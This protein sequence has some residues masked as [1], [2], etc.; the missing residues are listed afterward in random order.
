MKEKVK[1]YFKIIVLCALLLL[2]A[3]YSE[4]TNKTM[5]EDGSLPRNAFGE[6]SNEVDLVLNADGLEK[7]LPYEVTVEEKHITEKDA[8]QYF[9]QAESEI[10]STL[11]AEGDQATHVEHNLNVNTSYV[12]G[13]V[14][15]DWNFLDS[16]AINYEGEL[17]PEFMQASGEVVQVQVELTCYEYKETYAFSVQIYPAPL[18]KTEKLI[19]DIQAELEKESGK[20]DEDTFHLPQVVDGVKLRWSEPQE[21]L[22]LKIFLLEIIVCILLPFLEKEKQ[23][24]RLKARQERMRLDYSDIVSKMAILVGAGMSV[25][26]A[27]D[28]ISARYLVD[29]KKNMVI[30]KPAYEEM[31]T[32]SYELQDGAS[33]RD[34]FQNFSERVGVGEYHRLSRI[35]VQ[36]MEKG[37]KGICGMLEQEATDAFETRKLLARKLGEQASTKMMIP[38]MI[39]LVIVFAIIMVPAMM[40]LNM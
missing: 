9:E 21:H 18:N 11:Y 20:I 31:V 16:D 19:Q 23:K 17:R 40:G 35:L 14:Q 38:L 5:Q 30:E 36:S 1:R 26:Q 15:A 8:A 37:T 7:D 13:L 2:L 34:A 12:G 22:V 4:Q 28:T 33:E 24:E 29:R 27:W 39:M 3:Y 25:R 6:G 32:T 10:E